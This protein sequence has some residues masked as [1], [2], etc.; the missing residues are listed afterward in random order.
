M[1]DTNYLLNNDKLEPIDAANCPEV[2][3]KIDWAELNA[4]FFKY[5]F[6]SVE[7]HAHIID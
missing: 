6:P 4:S 2:T 3:Q 1:S 7:G 5:I